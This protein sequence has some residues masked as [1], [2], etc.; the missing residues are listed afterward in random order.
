MK[1]LGCHTDLVDLMDNRV[2]PHGM[3]GSEGLDD[4][5]ATLE[6]ASGI[7]VGF[8]V[9]NYTMNSSLKAVIERFGR[10][11]ENKVVGLMMAAGGRSSYMSS[12][13]VAASLMF[14]FRTWI[15]PRSV[16][17]TKDDFDDDRTRITSEEIKDR[18]V[19]LSRAIATKAW[20]H[21]QDAPFT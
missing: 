14:D 13:D 21:A 1:S 15:A 8:P 11:M 20:Q 2:L 3:I 6:T 9:Y 7:L 5:R 19:E 18:V 17:A 4:I 10:T 12:L 16:Y